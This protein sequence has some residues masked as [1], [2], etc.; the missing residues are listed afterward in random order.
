MSYVGELWWNKMAN[1]VRFLSDAEEFLELGKSVILNFTGD[2]PWCDILTDSLLQRLTKM[3]DT[4]TFDVHDVSGVK[5]TGEFLFKKYC[6]EEERDKYWPTTHNSREEFMAK[7]PVTPIHHRFVCLTGIVSDEAE[8]WFNSISRYIKS[9][10]A[11]NEH[12]LFILLTKNA[13][14]HIDLNLWRYCSIPTTSRTMTA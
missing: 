14:V 8:T 3:M 9:C 2:I 10:P 1:A 4:R 11:E 12:A 6:S 7:N 5:D 13:L